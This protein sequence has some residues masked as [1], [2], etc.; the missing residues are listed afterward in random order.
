MAALAVAV[1]LAAALA[2]AAARQAAYPNARY[3]GIRSGVELSR[4][5]GISGYGHTGA[6]GTTPTNV[7]KLSRQC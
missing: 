2:F 1:L 5:G 4:E 6:C 7:G 3:G